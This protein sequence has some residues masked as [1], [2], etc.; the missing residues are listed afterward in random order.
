MT[1]ILS[2]AIGHHKAGRLAEAEAL[3]R[4][5]LTIQPAHTDAWRFLGIVAL[6]VGRND[7]AVRWIS[8]AIALQPQTHDAWSHLGEAYRA[9][10][11]FEEAVTAFRR[12]LE[13]QPSAPEVYNNLGNVLRDQGRLDEAV[14]AFRKAIEL[15]ADLPEPYNNL[16]TVLADRGQVDEAIVAYHHAL[17]L[18]P[19][20]PQAWSNLGTTLTSRDR[21]DE[22]IAAQ[23]RAIE[24]DP[25]YA[26]AY[27]NLGNSLK[28]LGQL[29]EAMAAYRR[30]IEIQPDH[31]L[32]H[33]CLLYAAQ[34]LPGRVEETIAADID[35]WNRQF[36]DPL[37]KLHRPHSND[38]HPERLLRVAYVSPDFRRHPISHFL[39]SLLEAHDKAGFEIHCYSSVAHPNDITERIKKAADVWHDVFDLGD[40]ALAE[41]IR[42]D[43]I[44]ILVDLSQHT[45]NNR[46]RTFALKP[47]PVQISWLGYPASTGLPTFDYRFTDW[48]L[49]PEDSAWAESAE[50]PF[51]L[52]DCWFCY[53]PLDFPESSPLPA[54]GTGQVTFC[55]FHHFAKVNEKALALWAAVIRAVDN[56]RLLMH[57]PA[58]ATQDRVRHYFE[59]KGIAAHRLDLLP[60]TADRATFLRLF[61]QVD[62][63]LD[64]FPHNGGTTTCD[65]LWMGVPVVS[66]AGDRGVGRLGLTVLSN[67]G[68]PDLV[69]ITEEDYLGIATRLALDLPRLVELRATL[70]TRMQASPLMDAPRFARHMEAAYRSV[71]R[72]WCTETAPLNFL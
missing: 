66:L 58:G 18:R 7:L 72:R 8:Q 22:A 41:Q 56:S 71:W 33:H 47:A 54:L 4:Q 14:G 30:A 68:L 17:Q 1:D 32:A 57:C 9:L 31:P 53:D 6:Q 27:Y 5:V 52:P 55:A 12:A 19:N 46:L 51:R 49:D 2:L 70:R 42:A 64:S 40:S 37:R 60:R 65:A 23:R 59:S 28:D 15:H 29:T 61:R 25:H 20:Y 45:A 67:V 13:L 26:D 48:F 21:F 69:A 50:T 24:C 62:I 3:Y 44:D 38:R 39:L 43:R 36:A 16:A 35:R 63:G 10:G 11:R 34:L